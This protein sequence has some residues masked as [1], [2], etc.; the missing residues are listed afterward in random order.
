MK[1]KGQEE[2]EKILTPEKRGRGRPKTTGLITR[3]CPVCNK[4]VSVGNIYRQTCSKKCY[5]AL[6]VKIGKKIREEH[7]RNGRYQGVSRAYILDVL[8]TIPCKKTAAELIGISRSR[9]YQ[10]IGKRKN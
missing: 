1:S 5:H 8:R 10:I 2:L 9:L 4:T 7:N 3:Y 6:L